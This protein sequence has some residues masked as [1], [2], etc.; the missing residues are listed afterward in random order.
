MPSRRASFAAACA[1]AL[2]AGSCVHA[3][4]LLRLNL[5]GIDLGE[6]PAPVAVDGAFGWGSPTTATLEDDTGLWVADVTGYTGTEYKWVVNGIYEPLKDVTPSNCF[7]DDSYKNR[8]LA[9]R[10]GGTDVYN[11]CVCPQ[12]EEPPDFVAPAKRPDLK[13]S[14]TG[15]TF[16]SGATADLTR[17]THG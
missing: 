5:C 14:I 16:A 12:D 9:G 17:L 15:N 1:A 10:I 4:D 2:G 7:K 8:V 13:I 3:Q 11:S 6:P